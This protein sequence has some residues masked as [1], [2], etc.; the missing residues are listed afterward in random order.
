MLACFAKCRATKCRSTE[1]RGAQVRKKGLGLKIDPIDVDNNVSRRDVRRQ[2]ER[3]CRRSQFLQKKQKKKPFF[4][5]VGEKKLLT[6][7]EFLDKKIFSRSTESVRSCFS[8]VL[9]ASVN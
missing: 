1:C 8:K 4:L 7:S 9:L 2:M 6:G 5:E 3:K